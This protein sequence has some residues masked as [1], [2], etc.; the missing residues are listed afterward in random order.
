VGVYAATFGV[1]FPDKAAQ[2]VAA[3]V[4]IQTLPGL[5]AASATGAGEVDLREAVAALA[6]MAAAGCGLRVVAMHWGHE[7]EGFPTV[8]Q[9][10]VA[11]ALVR[12]GADVIVGAHAHVTQP[13]E[14]LLVNG[15]EESEAC[16]AAERQALAQLPAASRLAG[17]AGPPRKALVLYCLGATPRQARAFVAVR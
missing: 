14:I 17:V 9:M 11:R 10:A 3:G 4:A 7:F 1:N 8:P 12:A 16:S 5:A 15:Y 13:A 2:C 6:D